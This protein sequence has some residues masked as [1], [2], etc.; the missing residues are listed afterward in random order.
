M[1][2]DEPDREPL[3]E[4]GR[5][6][7]VETADAETATYRLRAADGAEFPLREA[8]VDDLATALSRLRA[9]QNDAESTPETVEI[10]C[11]ECG[12]T[13]QH[14]GSGESATCPDC[15]TVT[16]VEGAGP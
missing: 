1:T 4:E 11:H 8:D 14:A 7:I 3:V 16:T 6:T 5:M 9:R 2:T 10:T 13:W 15:G 12:K